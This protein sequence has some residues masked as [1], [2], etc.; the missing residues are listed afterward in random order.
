MVAAH[1]EDLADDA[2]AATEV[3]YDVLPYATSLT[4]ILARRSRSRSV[5][6]R[7]SAQ[8]GPRGESAKKPNPRR[9]RLLRSAGGWRLG[10]IAR[11]SDL[12]DRGR[13]RW[14]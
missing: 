5:G 14:P 13:P 9:V 12:L 8:S 10:F 6:S 4:Q 2:A 1:T 7:S 11:L 3:E